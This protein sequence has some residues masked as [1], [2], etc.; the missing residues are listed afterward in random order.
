MEMY[1]LPPPPPPILHGVDPKIITVQQQNMT[2]LLKG[3]AI[4]G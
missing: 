2:D 1:S 4:A 3:K